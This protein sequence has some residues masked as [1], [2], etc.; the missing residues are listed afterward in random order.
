MPVRR[1]AGML[2]ALPFI[3]ISNRVS[4]SID[5]PAASS[6]AA[7]VAGCGAAAAAAIGGGSVGTGGGCG[8]AAEDREPASLNRL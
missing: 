4:R 8:T 7:V 5:R 1:K 2:A 6:L 3:S